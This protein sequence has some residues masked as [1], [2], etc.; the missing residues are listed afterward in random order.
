MPEDEMEQ[1][2]RAANAQTL[3]LHIWTSL[4]WPSAAIE[5]LFRGLGY[6]VRSIAAGTQ[7]KGDLSP[8][9]IAIVG[10]DTRSLAEKA[11]ALRRL[12]GGE[13]KLACLTIDKPTQEDERAL[14]VSRVALAQAGGEADASFRRIV[15]A[16]GIETRTDV[17]VSYARLDRTIA[18]QLLKRLEEREIR[19]W[20]DRRDLMPSDL[21][22][23]VLRQG[24]ASS[25]SFLFLT[26][27]CALASK[28]CR[29]ELDWAE[30]YGKR[31]IGLLIEE[32]PMGS[33][34]DAIS[35]R[36]FIAS[37][38]DGASG[39]T[40]AACD[41]VVDALRRDPSNVRLH[42][43]LLARAI[44]YQASNNP[45]KL[46]RRREL[47]EAE[48]WLLETNARDREPRPVALHSRLI[49]ASRSQVATPRD[50][51]GS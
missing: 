2:Q 49:T 37:P 39:L 36:Q 3:D 19:P 11:A 31:I 22:R 10:G 26:S 51:I 9:A 32:L 17:F 48:A 34:P 24:I 21:W 47:R 43:D 25:D 41:E 1:R 29:E 46:L 6:A 18:D 35:R 27:A 23:Q 14:Q 40:E 15:A 12:Y 20:F 8:A 13:A 30:E 7:D 28:N 44:D 5:E 33:L 42:R 45:E 4:A 16:L 38:V 50:V